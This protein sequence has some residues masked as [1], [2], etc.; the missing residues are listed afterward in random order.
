MSDVVHSV[1]LFMT[2]I[3]IFY[4]FVPFSSTIFL[5]TQADP[6]MILNDDNGVVVISNRLQEGGVPP[7]EQG[8]VVG[9]LTL[10]DALI[11]GN[12]NNQVGV[13]NKLHNMSNLS[14]AFLCK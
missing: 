8:M 2:D 7:L 10:A 6:L 1:R 4:T 9:Q 12:C 11:I 3:H 5:P 13:L 14:S